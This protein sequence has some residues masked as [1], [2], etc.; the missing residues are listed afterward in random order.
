MPPMSAADFRFALLRS[1]PACGAR[2][3]VFHTPHGPVDTPAFMS[4]G[5]QATVKGLTVRNLR[6]TG[7]QMVLANTYHLALR[8]GEDVVR[9]CGG[10]HKFTGWTGPILTDSGGFQLFSLAQMTKVR[11]QEAVFR[12]HIDG[13]QLCLSPER[14]VEIQ[15]MLGS[16]VAMVLDHVVPLP[17]DEPAIRDACAR[18][19]RWA[20]RC[21]KAT[22]RSDQAQFAIVQGG[23]LPG[24]RVECAQAL[25]Q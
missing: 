16:D 6:E 5:T 3:G 20:E 18:T 25:A 21:K 10:L 14:A 7:A 19:I 22:K 2:R 24:L 9:D 4:V 8:P 1:D 13:S 17:S 11:E 12:S 15:E 23:L